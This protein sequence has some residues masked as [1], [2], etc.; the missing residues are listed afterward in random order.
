MLNMNEKQKDNIAKYSYDI[1]KGFFLLTI[2]NQYISRNM[3]ILDFIIGSFF[4]ISFLVLGYL[5]NKNK[6]YKK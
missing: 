6:G 3:T 2:V 1:S 5:L 4:T